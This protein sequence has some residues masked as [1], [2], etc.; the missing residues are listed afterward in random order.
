M[1]RQI[2]ERVACVDKYV[3]VCVWCRYF[4]FNHVS[5]EPQ[6]IMNLYYSSSYRPEVRFAPMPVTLLYSILTTHPP[7][8]I[9]GEAMASGSIPVSCPVL[10]FTLLLTR[11]CNAA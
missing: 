7:T 1:R 8:N 3:C 11:P 5:I 6:P 2:F 10:S 4:R 9:K